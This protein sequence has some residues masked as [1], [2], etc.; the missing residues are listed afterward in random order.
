MSQKNIKFKQENRAQNPPSY[1]KNL[2][3]QKSKTNRIIID[4]ENKNTEIKD[5][6]RSQENNTSKIYS[7]S[8]FEK[9]KLLNNSNYDLEFNEIEI[10]DNGKE[11]APLIHKRSSEDSFYNNDTET[12]SVKSLKKKLNELNGEISKLKNDSHLQNY[13]ILESNYKQKSKELTELKQENNFM[14][15]QLEDLM[16]KNIRSANSSVNIKNNNFISNY[17]SRPPLKIGIR[18]YHNLLFSKKIKLDED[19]KSKNFDEQIRLEL[20]IKKNEELIKQIGISNTELE[21]YKKKYNAIK[22]EKEELKLI[23]QKLNK[24]LNSY[25]TRTEIN[26]EYNQEENNSKFFKDVNDL[27]QMKEK[28]INELKKSLEESKNLLNEQKNKYENEIDEFKKKLEN[29]KEE[30]D[31]QMNE[32]NKVINEKNDYIIEID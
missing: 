20:Y 7:K 22:N 24:K 3:F 21:K 12:A 19:N 5:E 30:H 11:L 2:M 29:A 1:D 15:F 18:D 26:E 6:D 9:K 17:N 32:F 14:R 8:N 28:T 23:N 4:S 27:K 31:Q 10:K 16:R 25:R 13:N